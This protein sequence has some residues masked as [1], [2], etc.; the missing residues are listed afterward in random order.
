MAHNEENTQ[1]K[2]NP[3]LIQMLELVEDIETVII[4]A[5]HVF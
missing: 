1:S 5:F 4:T 3:E 2:T